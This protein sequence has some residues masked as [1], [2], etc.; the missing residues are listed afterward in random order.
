MTSI[1]KSGQWRSQALQL[2]Q[3]ALADNAVAIDA[4]ALLIA[5]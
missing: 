4:A 2:T 5:R 3:A 1:A